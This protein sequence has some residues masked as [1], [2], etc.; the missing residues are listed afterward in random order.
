MAHYA[1]LSPCDHF[2]SAEKAHL[3]RSVGWLEH[4]ES[5]TE[6]RVSERIFEK[7]C[8][9]IQN[10]FYPP[11][12][13]VSAG[14]HFCTLCQFSGG[15]AVARYQQYAFSG[16]SNSIVLIPGKSF[17]YIAPVHI[18]HYIDAHFYQ[19]PDEFCQAVMQCPEMRSRDY[20]NALLNNGGRELVIV[21]P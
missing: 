16:V 20:L 2:G 8:Q 18:A 6:G 12:W 14:L 21:R 13:P 19:P 1:D 3:L 5:Y 9:L 10:P 7:L 15:S 4:G 11:A 17:L